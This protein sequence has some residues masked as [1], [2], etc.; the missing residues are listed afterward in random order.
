MY[1]CKTNNLLEFIRRGVRNISIL[2]ISK[3][4]STCHAVL[5]VHCSLVVT[6]WER[7]NLLALLCEVFSCVF[8]T[9][10]R[11]VLGQVGG[12]VW[13]LIVSIPDLYLLSYFVNRT[14]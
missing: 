13:Y 2:T 10:P 5:S 8:V 1:S 12:Q 7:A 11:G 9:F 6:C 14:F 3:L 4:K